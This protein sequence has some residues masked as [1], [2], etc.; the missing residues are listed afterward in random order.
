MFFKTL[1]LTEVKLNTQ[2]LVKSIRAY[3]IEVEFKSN[4]SEFMRNPNGTYTMFKYSRIPS[5]DGTP[6]RMLTLD[7]DSYQNSILKSF[8]LLLEL[9]L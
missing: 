1:Q 2:T 4:Y 8:D 9:K 7:C 3:W 6:R 5:F